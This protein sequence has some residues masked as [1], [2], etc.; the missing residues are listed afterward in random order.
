MTAAS[1][2]H[3][4]RWA[5]RHHTATTVGSS[6]SLA[7]QKRFY[8]RLQWLIAV[9]LRR[10]IKI[11]AIGL[12]H[13]PQTGPAILVCNHRSDIDPSVLG[14]VIPRYICWVAAAYMKKVPLTGWIIKKT[15]MVLMDVNG[16][17]TPGSM[18]HALRVLDE[19][20][21]LGVFPEGEAY[22]FA[23]DF[24]APLAA[25]HRGFG[26]LALRKRVPIVPVMICPVEETLKPIRIPSSI[27]AE[28]GKHHDLDRI[29]EIVRYKRVRVVVGASISV[30]AVGGRRRE[31][32][33]EQLVRQVRESMLEIQRTYGD[34]GSIEGDA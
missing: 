28:I 22:I 23:N 19:G 5:V 33:L 24:S 2:R 31:E 8:R 4:L 21:M 6:M 17:V 20:E 27:R 15:G 10:F 32:V 30:E 25:F 3:R 29:K 7:S 26:V 1:K 14:S 13:V 34:S 12:E 18:K 11:E 9:L 16:K